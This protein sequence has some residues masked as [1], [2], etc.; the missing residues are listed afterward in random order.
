[1]LSLREVFY[2]RSAAE[3]SPVL[4]KSGLSARPEGGVAKGEDPWRSGLPGQPEAMLAGLVQGSSR[5]LESIPEET[6]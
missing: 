1:M 3:A 2:S 6:S 4:W 5:L